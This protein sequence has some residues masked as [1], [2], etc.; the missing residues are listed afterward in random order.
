[1][2]WTLLTT[3]MLAL[4]SLFNIGIT[5]GSN[6]GTTQAQFDKIE[7]QAQTDNKSV[8]VTQTLGPDGG[9]IV[10]DFMGQPRVVKF[11]PTALLHEVS[12]KMTVTTEVNK[13]YFGD[14]IWNM[15]HGVPELVDYISPQIILEIPSN[16]LDWQNVDIHKA[17]IGLS[18]RFNDGL[19]LNTHDAHIRAE[20]RIWSADN[21]EQ[22]ILLRS[23]LASNDFA[24]VA[25]GDIQIGLRNGAPDIIR[26]SMQ[27]VDKSRIIK[28]DM[29]Q[30][31]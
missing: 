21:S 20:I 17:L 27:V 24:G 10:V 31:D 11:A 22:L 15:E 3:I 9:S 1:M 4:A 29:G 7:V 12:I 2:N 23:Y 30:G 14:P 28:R 19:V 16:A 13:T 25:A 26:I 5:Y 18:P 6:T 8:T